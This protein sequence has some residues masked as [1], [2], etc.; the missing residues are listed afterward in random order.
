MGVSSFF[1]YVMTFLSSMAILTLAIGIWGYYSQPGGHGS[2]LLPPATI[3]LLDS[4]FIYVVAFSLITVI[5]EWTYRRPKKRKYEGEQ[6]GALERKDD[7]SPPT[8]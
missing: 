2:A 6:Y 7:E 3:Q 4:Y 1:E 5:G 8:R